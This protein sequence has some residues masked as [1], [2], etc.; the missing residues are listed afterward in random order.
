MTI[1]VRK[2]PE[3]KSRADADF[4]TFKNYVREHARPRSKE[5]MCKRATKHTFEEIAEAQLNLFFNKEDVRLGTPAKINVFEN[6]NR[7]QL[8]QRYDLMV[9]IIAG[10]TRAT[11]YFDVIGRRPGLCP[12]CSIVVGGWVGGWRR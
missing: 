11:L 7:S 9:R 2:G 8:S 5:T 12:P 1:H 6:R 10:R 4:L 3:R